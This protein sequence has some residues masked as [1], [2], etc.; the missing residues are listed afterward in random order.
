MLSDNGYDVSGEP[1]VSVF[2]LI[3][4][5]SSN[6]TEARMFYKVLNWDVIPWRIQRSPGDSFDICKHL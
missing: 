1:D 3:S 5:G 6:L 2:I 4:P